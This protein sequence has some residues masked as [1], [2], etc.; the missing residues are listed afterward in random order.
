MSFYTQLY[1]SVKGDIITINRVQFQIKDD[2]ILYKSTP[3]AAKL[4]FN[5]TGPLLEFSG[6]PPV[7][8]IDYLRL[9]RFYH[10][11][12]LPTTPHPRKKPKYYDLAFDIYFSPMLYSELRDQL[13]EIFKTKENVHVTTDGGGYNIELEYLQCRV[14]LFLADDESGHIIEFS[15]TDREYDLYNKI[16]QSC[17]EE[18]G[19]EMY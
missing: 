9:D 18:M 14:N 16:I 5:E 1:T 10:F 4:L 6:I 7:S 2:T 13:D 11:G 12:S 3:I 17:L 15:H 19:G 8:T